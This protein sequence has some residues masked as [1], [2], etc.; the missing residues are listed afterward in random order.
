MMEFCYK[1]CWKLIK[2]NIFFIWFQKI[3]EWVNSLLRVSLQGV[4]HV[5]K[6]VQTIESTHYGW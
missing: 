2:K 6:T 5:T 3:L 1:N 4:Y